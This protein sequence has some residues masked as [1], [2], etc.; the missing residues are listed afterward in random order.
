[1][2]KS[3]QA[4]ANLRDALESNFGLCVSCSTRKFGLVC[5]AMASK[6]NRQ[7]EQLSGRQT[8][9]NAINNAEMPK[10]GITIK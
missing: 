7:T 8:I 3:S 2:M 9:R 1:M 4:R 5:E 6:V 10:I